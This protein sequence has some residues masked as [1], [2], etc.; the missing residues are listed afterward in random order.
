MKFVS[1]RMGNGELEWGKVMYKFQNNM[2]PPAFDKYFTRPKH[3]YATR[4]ANENNFEQVRTSS[5]KE[6]TLLKFIGPKKWSDIPV[7]IKNSLDL[8]T[9]KDKYTTQLVDNYYNKQYLS[10]WLSIITV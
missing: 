1:I 9:F 4:Y 7:D 5:A 2:L 10:S 6:R 8:K 3:Q